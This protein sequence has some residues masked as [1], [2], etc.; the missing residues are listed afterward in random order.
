[1]GFGEV[2]GN[3]KLIG[4]AIGVVLLV[5]FL[6]QNF[7]MTSFQFLVFTLFVAPKWLVL[8][9]TFL[10]GFIFGYIY[11]KKKVWT[12]AKKTEPLV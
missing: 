5:I 11:A 10:L 8:T 1:M 7:E 9:V 4:I 2:K 6:L 3:M 12:E